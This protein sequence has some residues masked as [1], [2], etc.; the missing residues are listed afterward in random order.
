MIQSTLAILVLLLAHG[1]GDN[2]DA[3]KLATSLLT[4]GAST[5]DTKDAAAMAASYTDDAEVHLFGRKEGDGIEIKVYRGKEEIRG[6]YADLFKDPKPIHAKNTVE[7]AKQI[8]SDVLLI[9]G[10]FQTD[11]GSD[12]L[13]F[14][15]VRMK[16]GDKWLMVR[17][18]IFVLGS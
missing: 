12:P 16:Q 8:G 11:T 10:T 17:L 3:V 14:V 18:Q 5:F 4:Q 9:Q 6:L 2:E 15:Q 1:G 13:P 7:S